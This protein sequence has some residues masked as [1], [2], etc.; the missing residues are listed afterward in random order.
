[1]SGFIALIGGLAIIAGLGTTVLWA[2][3]RSRR[4]KGSH[5]GRNAL[6]MI[7]A[8]VVLLGVGGKGSSSSTK[9]GNA[10]QSTQFNKEK[11]SSHT[12]SSS[13]KKP[14][15]KTVTSSKKHHPAQK[16]VLAKLTYYTDKESAGPNGDYYFKNGK[17][18]VSGFSGMS[19]GDY[20]FA[21]DNQG[22]AGVAKARLTYAEFNASRGS[23]QGDP[24]EPSGWP[25]ENPIVAINF[26]LTGR[27]YHGYL[28]N[29][30]HSIGDSLLGAKSY[31]SA[32]N[33][34]TG[35]RPQNVGADQDGGMR[36][37]EETV[38][39]YWNS[40]PGTRQTVDYKTTPVYKGD[41]DIPR[42]S[43]VDIKSS[44]GEI[45]TEIVVINSVEGIKINY[46]TGTSNAK[47]YRRTGSSS[48]G[49][50]T[51]HS[52]GS[53]GTTTHHNTAA[54]TNGAWHVAA[55]GMVYV[56][57]SHKYYTQV[58]NP[59]NYQYMSR[60]KAAANGAS[61]ALRGNQYAKP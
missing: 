28:Y 2:T 21:S 53:Y 17:A 49:S 11:S 15:T 38:E 57:D 39:N 6:I 26:S 25:A 52:S 42:G 16:G 41:E 20:H 58:K 51:H 55:S 1:M 56:S 45:D 32:N 23:R 43:I 29:R 35:T 46:T 36:A 59:G 34:T 40:H 22:R 61:Q 8:G 48:Y 12:A 54:S 14:E 5:I 44:D 19:A 27:T 37:A 18:N 4:R 33:F 47:P 30:S 7:V 3:G 9:N 50:T 24:L 13:K 31:T 60:S 10:D